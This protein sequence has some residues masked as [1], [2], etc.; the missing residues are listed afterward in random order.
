MI[1][2]VWRT[3]KEKSCVF[4]K[5]I[6]ASNKYPTICDPKLKAKVSSLSVFSSVEY[7]FLF[8]YKKMGIS[9]AEWAERYS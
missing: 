3:A 8:H 2:D 6:I 7:D 9:T 1:S 4:R 5:W